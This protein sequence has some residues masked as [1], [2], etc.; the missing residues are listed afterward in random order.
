MFLIESSRQS[1]SFSYLKF[2]IRDVVVYLPTMH[3]VLGAIL[4]LRKLGMEV[5]ACHLRIQEVQAGVQNF[6]SLLTI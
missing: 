3:R 4:V 2:I 5:H 1:F 6:R